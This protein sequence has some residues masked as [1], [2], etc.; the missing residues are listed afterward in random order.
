M[1]HLAWQAAGPAVEIDADVVV[2]GT[3]AGGA[4]VARDLALG[5]S[6]VVMV[7][8]GAYRLPQD[9]P[10]S[11]YGAMRDVMDDW[12]SMITYG[13]AFW[14][15]V[16]GSVVGGTTVINS[17]IVVRTPPDVFQ[18]WQDQHGVGG[19]GMDQAVWDFQDEIEH[20][21]S[22]EAVPEAA[23]GRSN[24]LAVAGA[25]ALDYHDHEMLRNVKGCI[26]AGQ[27]VQGCRAGRKRS[28]NLTYVPEALEHG[29]TLLSCAPVNRVIFEG[30]RAVGVVGTFRH[31]LTRKKG[32]RFRVRARQAVVIAASATHS[33]AILH[34]S[35]VRSKALGHGFRAHPGTGIFGCYEDRVDLNVGATQG[36]STMRFRDSHGFKLESLSIPLELIASR[37]SGA[38]NQL[39]GRLESYPHIAMW[40]MAVRAED[41]AGYVKSGFGGKPFVRYTLVRKDMERMREG[42][43]RVAQ[44]HRA[45]G[46][47]S[48]IPGVF[49]MPYELA[50]DEIDLIKDAPLD[51]RAWTAILSHL[52]GGCVMGADATRSVCDGDGWVHGYEGLMVA[53]ASAMPSTIGVNPQHTIMGI[54][55][56]RA[57][58][59]LDA[60]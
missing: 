2:V 10:S 22:V 46:A 51:P 30:Q 53:D 42:A 4:T 9:Y 49:G 23:M 57:R 27:C 52:F 36:W 58:Q 37:L 34:R 7:E 6:S 24:Q 59:L 1:S 20:D 14:P 8:A 25:R 18:L 21:L 26:G 40:V 43:Y 39:M 33:P 47:K 55:R 41:S 45:A 56:L 32:A 54:A 15:I 11:M 16:Q 50:P 35:K 44:M 19:D 5:G 31:P 38:G 12:G 13:R 17:A 60:A 48:I 29:A 28:L 3:G